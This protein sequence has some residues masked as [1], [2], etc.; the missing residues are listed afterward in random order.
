MNATHTD[1]VL[2]SR[3]SVNDIQNALSWSMAVMRG[4]LHGAFIVTLPYL[5]LFQSMSEAVDSRKLAG[6]CNR[7]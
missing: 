6:S 2:F 4:L 5:P 1:S 7:R 3:G